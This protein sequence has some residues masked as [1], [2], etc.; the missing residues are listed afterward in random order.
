MLLTGLFYA[1]YAH[2]KET[3]LVVNNTGPESTDVEKTNGFDFGSNLSTALL[4]LT[5]GIHYVIGAK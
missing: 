4:G 1:D 2:D 3:D 5:L